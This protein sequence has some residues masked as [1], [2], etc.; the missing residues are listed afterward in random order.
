MKALIDHTS[1]SCWEL[2]S[3]SSVSN[4]PC[5]GE[6]CK[7]LIIKSRAA[8]LGRGEVERRVER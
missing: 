8:T 5:F 4:H 1:L 6:E 3:S 7:E 2:N